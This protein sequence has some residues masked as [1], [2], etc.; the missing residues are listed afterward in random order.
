[1]FMLNNSGFKP[2]SDNFY[3]NYRTEANFMERKGKKKPK[4]RNKKMCVCFLR[5]RT[6]D[7]K[8]QLYGGILRRRRVSPYLR[9]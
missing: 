6:R 2:S 4:G 8:A 7:T 9:C 3:I 1:M 5:V